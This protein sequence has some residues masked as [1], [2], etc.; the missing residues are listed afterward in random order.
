MQV[1][2]D[3]DLYTSFK[4]MCLKNRQSVKDAIADLLNYYVE[5]IKLTKKDAKK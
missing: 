2:V 5:P 1:L 3:E 4:I